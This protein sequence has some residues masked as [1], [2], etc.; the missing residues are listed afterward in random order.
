MKIWIP[1]SLSP[2]P[3]GI[4]TIFCLKTKGIKAKIQLKILLNHKE[5]PKKMKRKNEVFTPRFLR[6]L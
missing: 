1:Q 6:Y 3:S 4:K 5:N 2:T